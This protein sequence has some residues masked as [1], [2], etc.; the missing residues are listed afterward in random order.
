MFAHELSQSPYKLPKLPYAYDALEPFISQRLQELHHKGH[1]AAYVKG[2]NEALQ[3]LAA[4]DE[5]STPANVAQLTNE[6]TFNLA[7][8]ENHSLFWRSLSPVGGGKP[9]G[10]LAKAIS[11]DF[12]SFET[13]KARFATLATA[14]K[15]SGWVALAFE[16]VASRLVLLLLHDH[17][18]CMTFGCVPL[19]LLDMWEHAFYLDYQSN[20][21]K[22]IDAFWEV[23][24]WSSASRRLTDATYPS[25]E[26]A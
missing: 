18:S 14:T 26:A 5:G 7:G 24:D 25:P 13:F 4:T 10:M 22:Y 21:G 15:G 16:P 1:H 8:H 3:A 6:L 12:G 2:A 9:K 11:N 19:L 23:A 20:K 17:Q